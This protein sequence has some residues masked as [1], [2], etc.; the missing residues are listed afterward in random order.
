MKSS[1]VSLL[2]I[3]AG[4]SAAPFD[5]CPSKAFLVQG[6]TATI[7]GVNLVSGSYN[8]FAD[9]VGTNQKV[10]GFGFSVHDR[11]LYGWDYSRG[12]IG[13][14]G[15]DY[16]LEPLNASGLPNT[17][18]YVGDVSV[19]QNA[20]YV[21]R[22]GSDYGLYRIVLDEN[23][24]DYLVASKVID[25]SS[26]NLNIFDLA[27]H[28]DENLAYSVDNRGNLIAIDVTTGSNFNL[29]FTGV[30]GTFGAVYFDVEGYLY[31]SRNSD[32]HIF[33]IDINDP[34]STTL[35]A[36]GP[37]S[38]NNDGARCATAPIIDESEAPTLDYGDAP[39]TYATS[40][41]ANGARHGKGN[42]Y[43][44]NGVSAEHTPNQVDDDD[45]VNFVTGLETGL[46][47]LVS[48]R[49]SAPGYV[50]AWVDWNGNGQ[51]D[52]SEQIITEHLGTVGENRILIEV[53][54]DAREGTTWA[55]F[56]VS[57][58]PSISPLGGVDS[59][60]VEDISVSIVASG[61]VETATA[62]QTAAFEDLWPQQGDYDFND[63]VVKYRI[64]KSQIGNQVVRLKIDGELLAV[65][66]SYHNGFAFRF[67]NIL[68]NQI[69]EPLVRLTING[70]QIA[71]N[72]L[73][74]GR[75]EAILI[76]LDDTKVIAN[77]QS[78]CKYFR[79]ESGC[80]NQQPIPFSVT[81]PFKNTVTDSA[82]LISGV[83]PFIF[84]VN[85]FD[86]GPFV[87]SNNARAWEV[88]LKNHTPTEAFNTGYFDQGDDMSSTYGNF[89]TAN[90]LPWAL[91]I[92]TSW[93]HPKESTDML[94]AYPEFG[95]FAE[96]AGSANTNWF[97]SAVGQH[98][99]Q[100]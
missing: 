42:L 18:F 43:F 80:L 12:N 87:D 54:I 55:R 31:I 62:W 74:A 96:S 100:N 30:T 14:I 66:A 85:G 29:G 56:R 41:S 49:L 6:T 39:D 83:S 40:I 57:N 79:T 77:T 33:R 1:I 45:G 75:N 15:K 88:H 63:V 53:P 59:G 46:D 50:N 26:L 58:T 99:V 84:A 64:F 13:R 3:A 86:H 25:G 34:T 72:P 37:S 73:E 71:K 60:E 17:N 81:L 27:F 76:A 95:G 52:E 68:R 4:S 23:D 47:T 36:Y 38:G 11:Y 32:G 8:R 67:A 44:G 48:Y 69:D 93:N 35:F 21:Y 7:F 2:F 10:N 22:K 97:R 78:G 19:Q 51:F 9:N 89:Q 90:G 65:G 28:P 20:Y 98:S 94:L 92:G 61:V 82:S 16:A 5:T 24:S 91:I 70:Q